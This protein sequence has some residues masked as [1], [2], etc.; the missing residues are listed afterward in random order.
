MIWHA[1]L[2]HVAATSYHC[3]LASRPECRGSSPLCSCVTR[4]MANLHLLAELQEIE[5]GKALVAGH[6]TE[7]TLPLA[8]LHDDCLVRVTQIDHVRWLHTAQ[9]S[10]LAQFLGMQPGW[11]ATHILL[12][13][14]RPPTAAAL[15]GRNP[16]AACRADTA[17]WSRANAANQGVSQ[18]DAPGQPCISPTRPVPRACSCLAE[19]GSPWE[20]PPPQHR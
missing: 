7:C 11:R 19:Q 18:A 15:P 4:K 17:H 3:M 1:V 6:H 14:A 20:Q 13:T 5:L 16:G 2:L 9:W 8:Q 10:R 12:S